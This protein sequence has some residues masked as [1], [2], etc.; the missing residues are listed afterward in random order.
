M[1]KPGVAE[2]AKKVTINKIRVELSILD[3]FIKI[4]KRIN[5]LSDKPNQYNDY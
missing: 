1:H 2:T 5:R 4:F 3:A